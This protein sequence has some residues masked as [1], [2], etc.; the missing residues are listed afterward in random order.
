MNIVN[1][2]V[3]D[4]GQFDMRSQSRG[5]GKPTIDIRSV[6]LPTENDL[7]KEDSRMICR[8]SQSDRL[9]GNS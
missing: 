3:R 4:A 8:H 1:D 6:T 2:V 9:I 5:G 7:K